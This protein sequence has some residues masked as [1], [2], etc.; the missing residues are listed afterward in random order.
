MDRYWSLFRSHALTAGITA[1]LTAGAAFGADPIADPVADRSAEIAE[2][3]VKM[4]FF[5]APWPTVLQTLAD[6]SGSRLV[7]KDVPPGRFSRFDRAAYTRGEAVKLLNQRLEE[8]GFR[9]LEQGANLI[10]LS[11]RSVRQNYR[12]PIAPDAAGRPLYAES[13]TLSPLPEPAVRRRQFGS[14]LPQRDASGRSA[15]RTARDAAAGYAADRAAA[16][17]AADASPRFPTGAVRTADLSASTAAGATPVFDLASG[18]VTAPAADAPPETVVVRT[19]RGT[20]KTVARTL[21]LAAGGRTKLIDRG[22]GGFPA[23]AA[24]RP[25]PGGKPAFAEPPMYSVGVDETRD[26]LVVSAP[27]Q[28][29]THVAEALRAI[30]QGPEKGRGMQVVAGGPAT[31]GVSRQL[32]PVF[33][34]LARFRRQVGAPAAQPP[35]PPAAARPTVAQPPAGPAQA[36]QTPP[37]APAPGQA[38]PALAPPAPALPDPA[39]LQRILENI[40][41]DVQVEEF[42]DSGVLI[43]RGNRDDVAAVAQVINQTRTTVRGAPA[44]DPTSPAQACRQRAAGRV[45]DGGLRRTGPRCGTAASRRPAA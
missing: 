2:N 36:G 14:V 42:G 20:A 8:D 24:Y 5:N 13:T 39:E 19:G 28:R 37:A 15:P 4:R 45:T 23:F 34:T 41:S 31:A 32:K 18:E 16:L 26:E 7:M 21:M 33:A 10:V 12:R 22:P 27:G 29:A 30:D 43:I 6:Q 38:P 1:L 35:A 9:I 11:D 25:G 44:A 40:R 3:G 17:A